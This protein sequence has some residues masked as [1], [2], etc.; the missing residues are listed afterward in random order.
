MGLSMGPRQPLNR[1]D[2]STPAANVISFLPGRQTV[3]LDN[4]LQA[5]LSTTP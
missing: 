3:V 4:S 5:M 1:K 2:P